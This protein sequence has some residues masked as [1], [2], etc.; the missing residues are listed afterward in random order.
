MI[1]MHI[2]TKAGITLAVFCSLFVLNNAQAATTLPAQVNYRVLL[3]HS[4]L[5]I[6]K[7][8]SYAMQIERIVEPL[9]A[10]GVQNQSQVNIA[11]PGNFAKLKII[12]AYTEDPDGM[13]HPVIA[14]EI[15]L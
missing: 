7:N 13:R 11:Y 3:D 15:Y 8:D 4:T 14:S 6:H 5:I 1:G 12:K 10:T 2:M 9:N